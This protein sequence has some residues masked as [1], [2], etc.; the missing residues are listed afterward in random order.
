MKNKP[1]MESF[2][3]RVDTVL[4]MIGIVCFTT[5]PGASLVTLSA[6]S[7]GSF[8]LC[9]RKKE[10]KVYYMKA[11]FLKKMRAGI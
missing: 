3:G 2:P 5:L 1:P 10:E 7:F 9:G 11:V 6:C 8:S 4:P